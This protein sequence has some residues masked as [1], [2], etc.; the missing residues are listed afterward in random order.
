MK[1]LFICTGNTCRSPMAEYLARDYIKKN[2]IRN[3]EVSSCGIMPDIGEAANPNAVTVMDELGIDIS[4]HRAKRLEAEEITGYDIFA[5]MSPSQ[6]AL[7]SQCGVDPD[8]IVILGGGIH[9]PY[10]SGVETYRMTRDRLNTAVTQ[11]IDTV[12][13]ISSGGEAEK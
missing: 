11:L 5:V 6:L 9:D 12:L 4:A 8:R 1:L 10:G 7:L 3:I 13:K 2:N